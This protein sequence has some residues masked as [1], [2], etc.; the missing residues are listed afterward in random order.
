ML[1]AI[2]PGL[3]TRVSEF[4]ELFFVSYYL[5]TVDCVHAYIKDLYVFVFFKLLSDQDSTWA[6]YLVVV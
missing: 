3:S 5:A 6:C 4:S 2:T 1:K